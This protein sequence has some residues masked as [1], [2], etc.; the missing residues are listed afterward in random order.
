MKRK[1]FSLVWGRKL[2]FGVG[3]PI[4]LLISMSF[5]V[6]GG[7]PE[8]VLSMV[9]LFMQVIGQTGILVLLGYFLVFY[10]VVY[11]IPTYYFSRIWGITILNVLIGA[12]FLDA[13]SYVLHGVH[14]NS[15][16]IQH[17]VLQAEA[18]Q[19]KA[20]LALS[21]LLLSTIFLWLRGNRIWFLMQRK[22]MNT[23]SRWYVWLIVV[24]FIG[25]QMVNVYNQ[26][27]HS[28]YVQQVLE[29]FPI[30]IPIPQMEFLASIKYKEH[31]PKDKNISLPKKKSFYPKALSCNADKNFIFIVYE[32]LPEFVHHFEEHGFKLTNNFGVK[33]SPQSALNSLIYSFPE[34]LKTDA[35]EESQIIRVFKDY[36]YHLEFF[37]NNSEIRIDGIEESKKIVE[38]RNWIKA[39]LES[40][41]TKNFA[42]FMYIDQGK[43]YEKTIN[44]I[45]IDLDKAQVLD[46]TIVVFTAL[47]GPSHGD[48]LVKTPLTLLWADHDGGKIDRMTTS[49][50]LMPTMLQRALRCNGD[51]RD[52]S[53][54]T[55]FLSDE[56]SKYFVYTEQNTPR[57][58]VAD[59][60]VN[61]SLQDLDY[62][63][64]DIDALEILNIRKFYY[65]FFK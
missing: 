14:L 49:Y 54:G 25:A 3:W 47:N 6:K 32:N 39:Y 30:R 58:W 8:S 60:D 31:L 21:P 50:D 11:L 18:L 10:P 23:N 52:Y 45:L 15:F 33:S 56:E 43:L 9:L 26:I 17:L 44:N 63:S 13:Y 48:Q 7:L 12:C 59:K 57:I 64:R 62:F 55:N 16:I 36:E 5:V 29:Q 41:S 61:F 35:V 28:R 22:F 42:L 38:S 37:S 19:W 40:S 65:N 53:F 1:N 27:H 24:S 20:Y 4:L 51:V 34:G 2:F 46:D